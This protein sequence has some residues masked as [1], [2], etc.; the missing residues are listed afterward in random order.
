MDCDGLVALGAHANLVRRHSD[1]EA[2]QQRMLAT[3]QISVDELL[4]SQQLHDIKR[5]REN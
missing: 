3:L 4:G 2:G 1:P 5:S